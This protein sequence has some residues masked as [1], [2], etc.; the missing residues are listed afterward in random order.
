MVEEGVLY[1]QDVGCENVEEV[2]NMDIAS[3]NSIWSEYFFVFVAGMHTNS[4]ADVTTNYDL[5]VWVFGTVHGVKYH[6]ELIMAWLS[7]GK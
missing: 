2:V 1:S 5:Y 6:T 7:Q 4:R 3:L